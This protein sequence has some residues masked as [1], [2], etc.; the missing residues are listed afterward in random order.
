MALTIEW[1]RRVENWRRELPHHVYRPL[2]TV[3]L[4][5]FTTMDQLRVEEARAHRFAAMPTGMAWGAKWE[6]AWFRTQVV[7]PEAA[8]SQRIVF[9]P[10]T[11]GI[12]SAVYV[13]GV[14][15]GAVDRE[16]TEITLARKGVP[17]AR[18]E[19]MIESYAGHG[20]RV[21]SPGP[22]PPG[23]ET[24]PEPPETQAVVGESTFGVWQ[25]DVYQLWLDVEAL[26]GLRDSMDPESLRVAEIDQGLRDL[27]VIVDFELPREEML[28]TVRACRERLR[29]LLECVN[30][31]TAPRMYAFGHSHIDV[32]WLW[33][34]AETE[35][36]C[37]RT[38]GSQLAMCDEYPDYRFLQSQPHLYWMVKTKYPDLYAR[39]KDAVQRGQFI[40]EGGMWVEAD[41][42]VS[43]GESLI[44]QFIHGKR[45]YRDEFG[46]ECQMLWLPDVFGYSGNMPQIMRGCGIEYFATAKI[47]WNYN[48]G[49]PFPFNNFVWEGIDGSEVLAHLVNDYN[50]RTDVA[51][52]ILRWNQRVQKDGISARLLPFGWGDGGGGPTRDHMEYVRRL[53]DLEGAPKVHIAHPVD[54]FRD[55]QA[56]GAFSNRYVGEL[57]LQVHRGTYTSQARTKRGNRKSELALR[58]AEM[59]AAAAGA[60][61]GYRVPLETLDTAWKKV[62]L[63]Q[64][65][66]IIPGSSIHRV[67][68]E[69]EA[70]YAEVVETAQGVAAAATKALTD[71]SRALTVFNSLA[72]PRTALVPLPQG[73]VGAVSSS[74]KPLPTQ[75]M[76]DATYVEVAVPSCG[77]TTV[78]LQGAP[79]SAPASELSATPRSLE[80]AHLRLAFNDRGEITSL[81]DKDAGRELA[82][83]PCNS[84]KMYKDV[85]TS[86]DAWDVDS[87]YALTPVALDSPAAIE[88]L[89]EGPLVAQLRVTRTLNGSPMTQVISLRR[90]SRRVDFATELDWRESHKLLKVAFPVDVHANEAV[91]EIQFGHIR[92]PNHKSRPFD[93]DRFEVANQ[94][95]TALMEEARG[96][97]VL[98]DCKYGINVL[99]N[100]INLT[101]L[102]SPLAPDM[103]ADK[104]RQVFTYAFY[105]W[106]GSF[107]ECDLVREAYDLNCPVMTAAGAAG[108]RSLFSV[109][110][111][112]V[113]IETVKPAE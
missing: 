91:H 73:S 96:C 106:N 101:L 10:K 18:Y 34:L 26:I 93:A 50:S 23:R 97:A 55:Q 29:P 56:K 112:N 44:R 42:N 20:P 87:M 64:F 35:R 1:R 78:S 14:A 2:G 15:A 25:E 28:E 92:R 51:T 47:F 70:S 81:Y 11:G 108:E 49:D 84:L 110:S 46:V 80:N 102:K 57:Y 74:S 43:G 88:V 79:A 71:G 33:P 19:L 53:R 32:A 75:Q 85:P 16:H 60:L 41:T 59:W 36:K 21:H 6:Y 107:A 8:A 83:G 39:V 45:F 113:V 100:S 104:G 27:T 105:A 68:E 62:L 52:V 77:W 65:H 76:A 31:S 17:G 69:A 90:G 54:Y 38:F 95:W 82:V 58:E 103:T 72:W 99:D 86:W 48:G 5:G 40:A 98:N 66:D 63:N 30:G 7:L 109:D 37:V 3:P 61:A 89:A 24:V 22:V 9:R 13:G 12:E 111:A 4:E 67:Y 94:K